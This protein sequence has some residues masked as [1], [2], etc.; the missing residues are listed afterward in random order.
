MP[1]AGFD[2]TFSPAKSVSVLWALADQ[3]TRAAI[4]AAHHP[5]VAQTLGVIE[6]D[7]ARTRTGHAGAA[8]LPTRGLIAAGFDHYDS[9][10]GDPQLHTHVTVANRVQGPDGKWR[11]LHATELY[12]ATVAVSATYDALLANHVTRRLGLTWETRSRDRDRNPAHELTA[13][14]QT[15]ITEFS[16]RAAAI[17][18]A[19]AHAI[20]E[21]T[22]THGRG[23]TA[24]EVATIRQQA[25]LE[26]REAKH[27]R[28]LPDYTVEWRARAGRV[29]HT[30]PTAWVR[31]VLGQPAP[32]PIRL[33]TPRPER[34]P[35]ATARTART[36]NAGTIAL[37]DLEPAT[38]RPVETS[39]DT[40]ADS[41]ASPSTMSTPQL[42]SASDVTDSAVGALSAAVVAATRQIADHAHQQRTIDLIDTLGPKFAPTA[43]TPGAQSAGALQ[44]HRL[45]KAIRITEAYGVK[46]E[47]ALPTLADRSDNLNQLID[48]YEHLA[49]RAQQRRGG[50]PVV[51]TLRDGRPTATTGITDPAV[52]RALM[53]REEILDRT[54]ET[55]TAQRHRASTTDY[56]IDHS[57]PS[58]ENH[59]G[60]SR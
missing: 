8:V 41:V 5:A 7:V 36:T 10:A 20:A 55:L 24:A 33:P 52:R 6:R 31:T 37:F 45:T 16:R 49:A 23:P 54:S 59:M 2:L 15:L 34:P 38:N 25:T 22:A 1:V 13:I 29:L 60:I 11:T 26:T 44:I 56:G 18:D 43:S 47:E 27:T 4:V 53:D 19:G 50:R 21:F 30:D 12:R 48:H 28:P 3:H 17:N 58:P 39:P 9:R 35:A 57:P 40:L 42:I 32:Q 14:P 51:R 46:V